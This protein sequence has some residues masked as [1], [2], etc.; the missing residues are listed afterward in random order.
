MRCHVHPGNGAAACESSRNLETEPQPGNGAATVRERWISVNPGAISRSCRALTE[1]QP[2]N[3]AATVRERWISANPRAS[4]LPG[5]R[6]AAPAQSRER[7]ERSHPLAWVQ[8]DKEPGQ[9]VRKPGGRKSVAHGAS[10]ETARVCRKAP[11]RGER[12][13]QAFLSPR[14]GARSPHQATHGLRRGLHSAALTGS[15]IRH[16]T[17][18]GHRH[19]WLD[20]RRAIAR[21]NDWHPAAGWRLA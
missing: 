5:H 9:V 3:G 2:G 20:V 14:S 16:F 13:R 18:T 7:R 1:P 17:R 4:T 12:T 21:R 10:R 15:F 11:E 8:R 6:G 19:E